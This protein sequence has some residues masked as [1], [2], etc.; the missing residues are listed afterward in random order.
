LVGKEKLSFQTWFFPAR[1]PTGCPWRWLGDR[2]ICTL[3]SC[4]ASHSA[5][6]G[7]MGL[8]R[9]RLVCLAESNN[10]KFVFSSPERF[11]F[12]LTFWLSTFQ[13]S[14]DM[15]E[16]YVLCLVFIPT[17]FSLM[18]LSYW[19]IKASSRSM[20]PPITTLSSIKENIPE[21]LAR[22]GDCQ[23]IVLAVGLVLNKLR[24]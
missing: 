6:M 7:A 17:T 20:C 18:Y 19:F 4:V 11:Y 16:I 5:K 3:S 15:K 9:H 23:L 12:A 14:I 10:C 24:L 2:P 13:T 22:R 21:S 1:P 8:P